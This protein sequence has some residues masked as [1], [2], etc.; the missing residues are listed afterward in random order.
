MQSGWFPLQEKKEEDKHFL[1]RGATNVQPANKKKISS[2]SPVARKRAR[3]LCVQ[4]T[5]DHHQQTATQIGYA[6]AANLPQVQQLQE[7]LSGKSEKIRGM[8]THCLRRLTEGD[9]HNKYWPPQSLDG[10]RGQNVK[11]NFAPSLL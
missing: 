9:L 2:T 6:A 4:P 10:Q 11:A 8:A 7:M 1:S 3:T 5:C